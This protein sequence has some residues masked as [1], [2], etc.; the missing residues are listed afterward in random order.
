MEHIL[1]VISNTMQLVKSAYDTYCG[2]SVNLA[3]VYLAFFCLFFS[4]RKKTEKSR[5]DKF[6]LWLSVV[7][8]GVIVCPVSAWFIM[9]YCVAS[10]VYR[11]MFWMIPAPLLIGYVG[12][13][14]VAGENK[15][16]RK[17]FTGALLTGIIVVTGANLYTSQNFTKASN[18]YK[19]MPG[20]ISVCDVIQ[21]D[22]A[23]QGIE[24]VGVFA[25]NDLV[26]QIRQ[27]D[28]SIRMPYGRDMINGEAGVTRLAKRVY[29]ALNGE[30]LNAQALAFDAKKGNYQYLV[31]WS[32]ETLVS[33]LAEA[34]YELIED[35]GGY[36]VYRLDMEKVS[37]ILITQY[38]NNEGNQMNFYTIETM[39][40][41]LIVIDGGFETDEEYVREVLSSKG[42]RVNAWIL[43]HY[44]QDHVGAF[45]KIY[46]NPGNIRIGK[47]YAVSM[48]PRELYVEN[49]PW[50]ETYTYERFQELDIE[51]INYLHAGDERKVAGVQMKVLSA[52]D[53]YVDEISNDLHNDGSMMF[54]VYGEKESMLFCADVGKKMSKWIIEHYGEEL[55]SDYLQMGH[56]GNGGLSEE[57]YRM[58]H[59]KAAFFD[60]PAWLFDST[61]EKYTSRK[62]REIVE[63]MGAVIYSF[64]GAPHSVQLH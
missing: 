1:S 30:Q 26:I 64:E 49:A 62:N 3:I 40:G 29:Q 23:S 57:F 51:E 14:I 18:P 16:W 9:K 42:K 63:D 12:A 36:F 6:L 37:D 38:G 48:A 33:P 59:P 27:Y 7:L 56:H 44:H 60:A 17:F 61:E 45:C 58:V 24:D 52:Y 34:G 13:G 4:L 41:K 39:K 10:N 11:R 15:K 2:A 19:L 22:A 43:T 25:T 21:A 53:D 54:K 20:V 47:I 8:A 35:V 32:D 55:S 46:E 31:T 5:Q 28:A 50:D